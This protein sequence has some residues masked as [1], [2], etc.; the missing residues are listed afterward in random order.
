VLNPAA[1][2]VDGLIHLLYRATPTRN[3]GVAGEYASSVGVATSTDGVAFTA[4][5]APLITP[6]EPYEA[7]LGCE[8]PR[9][10]R[11]GDRYLIFYNAVD[12][13]G[14]VGVAAASTTDFATATKHGLLLR[15]ES[16]DIRIKAAAAFPLDSGRIGLAFT[17]ATESPL[18]S[19]M[20]VEHPDLD[21]LLQPTS[22][23]RLGRLLTRYGEY[24]LLPPPTPVERGPEL[25]AAPVRTD[26]GWLL[27]YCPANRTARPQWSI[28]ALLLDPD[29]PRVVLGHLPELL[30]PETDDERIGVVDNVAFPSGTVVRDGVLYVYYGAGD[31]VCC[32][33][34]ADLAELLAALRAAPLDRRG[35][36]Y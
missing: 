3:F 25:G 28:G 26:D 21:S 33:A 2:E 15:T 11:I 24:V 1:I 20:Y 8:D 23:E 12:P 22:E 4:R 36:S 17:L 27:V 32:L 9:V 10:S 13:A 19:L 29:D 35:F 18:G 31:Q 30:L 5:D 6:T 14:R 7:G 16:P 34:T